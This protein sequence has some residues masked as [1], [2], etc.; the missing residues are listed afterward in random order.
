MSKEEFTKIVKGEMVFYMHNYSMTCIHM[1]LIN[2]ILACR[3]KLT[4]IR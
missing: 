4:L 3:H 1:P 2:L